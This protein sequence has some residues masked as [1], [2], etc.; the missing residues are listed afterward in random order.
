MHLTQKHIA[1]TKRLTQVLKPLNGWISVKL[2]LYHMKSL[3]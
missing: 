1:D 3:Q 2:Y